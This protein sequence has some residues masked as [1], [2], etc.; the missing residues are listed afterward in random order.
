MQLNYF[1]YHARGILSEFSDFLH[2]LRLNRRKCENSAVKPQ[3]MRKF[4]G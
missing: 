4:G 3:K 2:F 1:G